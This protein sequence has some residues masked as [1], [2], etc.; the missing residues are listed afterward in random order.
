M[1]S[2]YI[3][4]INKQ[5]KRKQNSPWSSPGEERGVVPNFHPLPNYY[6][7]RW[8]QYLIAKSQPRP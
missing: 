7:P 3:L 4:L 8:S 1:T 6:P 2:L 5:K